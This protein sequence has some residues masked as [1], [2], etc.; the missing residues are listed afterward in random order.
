M[1]G[2]DIESRFYSKSNVKP[3]ESFKLR[4]HDLIAFLKGHLG[5]YME[6]KTEKGQTRKQRER[7]SSNSNYDSRMGIIVEA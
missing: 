7:E 3:F 1:G 2:H 4:K 5:C 6:N